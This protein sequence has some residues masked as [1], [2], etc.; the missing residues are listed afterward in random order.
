YREESFAEIREKYQTHIARML[1]LAGLNEPEAQAEAIFQ[2]ETRIAEYHWD[3]VKNREA[4]LTYNLR[5]WADV[6]EQT[7]SLFEPWIQA[8]GAPAGTFDEIVVRQPSFVEGLAELFRTE[9]L[10]AWRAWLRWQLIRSHAAYLHD[11]AAEANFDFYG[12]TLTGQPEMRVRW[13][14]GVS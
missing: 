6:N 7:D 8:I 10:G 3:K 5:S 4:T 13:K 14:R 9:R 2:L 12:R 1:K 11:E